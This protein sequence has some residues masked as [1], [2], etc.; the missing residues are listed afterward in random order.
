MFSKISIISFKNG[1]EV[2]KY[3]PFTLSSGSSLIN[4]FLSSYPKETDSSPSLS[5][6]TSLV[7]IALMIYVSSNT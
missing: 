1:V 7:V 4:E 5:L 2:L 3:W 6:K